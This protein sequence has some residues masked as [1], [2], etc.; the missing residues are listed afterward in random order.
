MVKSDTNRNQTQANYRFDIT[1]V[2]QGVAIIGIDPFRSP[3]PLDVI[4]AELN[5][6]KVTGKFA[7]LPEGEYYPN[8]IRPKETITIKLITGHFDEPMGDTFA[9]PPM[10]YSD[11]LGR[12]YVTIVTIV[13][14]T[15]DVIPCIRQ[16]KS[17]LIMN[18]ST[19]VV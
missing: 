19:W 1:N 18:M 2:G 6:Q 3:Q 13:P 15:G 14:K 8:T 16:S 5:N 7:V 4:A 12:K 10:H 11:A 17:Y 9:L